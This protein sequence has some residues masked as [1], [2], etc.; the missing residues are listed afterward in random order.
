ML[1]FCRS[2]VLE[3]IFLRLYPDF[4]MLYNAR[5]GACIPLPNMGPCSSSF[6]PPA[7]FQASVSPSSLGA[8]PPLQRPHEDEP[9]HSVPTPPSSSDSR[10]RSRTP[11]RRRSMTSRPRSA[12]S[13]PRF[14][15]HG[16]GQARHR[17][18]SHHRRS[19]SRSASRRPS[20]P[21]ACTQCFRAAGARAACT[22]R[23]PSPCTYCFWTWHSWRPPFSRDFVQPDGSTATTAATAAAKAFVAYINTCKSGHCPRRLATPRKWPPSSPTTSTT[24]FATIPDYTYLQPTFNFIPT[25]TS[26]NLASKLE[27]HQILPRQ[28]RG[29]HGQGQG[30]C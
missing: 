10:R 3:V 20:F 12:R 7:A 14:S 17:R 24:A 5:S 27:R 13:R 15:A 6:A 11:A 18:H 2:F 21:G 26:T 29:P 16:R 4:R 1:M 19:P 23:Q 9:T 28:H 22:L 25:W 30:L 8:T